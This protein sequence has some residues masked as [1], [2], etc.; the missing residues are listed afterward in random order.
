MFLPNLYGR[1]TGMNL[2]NA[3]QGTTGTTGQPVS[4]V[5]TGLSNCL[6]SIDLPELPTGHRYLFEGSQEQAVP[7]G[8]P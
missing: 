2:K 6:W 4:T 3:S 5:G 1:S 8:Y 7:P